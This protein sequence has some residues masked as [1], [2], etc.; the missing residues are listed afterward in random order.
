MH[1]ASR[2][3]SRTRCRALATWSAGALAL[4]V[5]AA[6]GALSP[7]AP[8]GHGPDPYAHLVQVH[9]SPSGSDA[10]AGT[11]AAPVRSVAEG[12]ARAIENR[13]NGQGTRVNLHPGVYRESLLGNYSTAG[14][15]LLVIHAVHPGT[16]TVAGSD[17]WTDWTCEGAVCTHVWPFTWGAAENPWPDQDIGELAL[18]R[19]VIVVNGTMLEQR[20]AIDALVPGSF[21]VDE[22]NGRVHLRPPTGADLEAALVEVAVR[23]TLVR[24]QGLSDLVLKGVRFAHAASPFR[25]AAVE[26]VDQRDVLIEDSVI[27]WNG[28]TGISLKGR[29]IT[30]RH[31]AM[32]HNGSSGVSAFQVVDVLLEDT[33]TA[34]NNWRGVAGDYTGWEVGQ[35]FFSAHRLTLRRHDSHSNAT[36]GFWIDT[37]GVDVLIDDSRFC[38][39]LTNGLFVEASQGPIIVR[40]SVLCRNEQSGLVTSATHGL[41]LVGNVLDRNGRSQVYVSGDFGRIVTDWETGETHVLNNRDW[42]WHGNVMTGAGDALLISTTHPPEHWRALMGAADFD[43]NTY[44]HDTSDT[45]RVPGGRR[46]DFG[47]WQDETNQDFNSSFG[48]SAD[49][50]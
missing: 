39:N 38:D 40:D 8:Q 4:T 5:L 27:E 50:P 23:P 33:E 11:A 10:W 25:A 32:N 17:V 1:T 14:G 42:T 45:F 15:A 18:R 43:F 26:I 9:V 49:S 28:Q 44:L 12:L 7:Q 34:H 35:K 24:L 46:L 21:Y 16:V 29:R 13:A 47:D 48:F 37:D 2:T 19:E 6:C 3:P 41:T 30:L 31:T 22:E 36:R 20:L